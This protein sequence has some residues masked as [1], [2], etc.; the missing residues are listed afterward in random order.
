MSVTAPGEAAL[1]NAVY[2]VS[3]T[4]DTDSDVVLREETADDVTA[5]G[6]EKERVHVVATDDV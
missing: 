1:V 5:T 2:R 3:D 6:S 4:M